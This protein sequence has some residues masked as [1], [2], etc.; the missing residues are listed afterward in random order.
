LLGGAVILS[1]ALVE[2]EENR[3]VLAVWFL[4]VGVVAAAIGFLLLMI[5]TAN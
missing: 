1:A 5:K 4:V 2:T 3:A